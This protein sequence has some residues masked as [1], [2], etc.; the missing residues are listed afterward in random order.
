MIAALA[1]QFDASTVKADLM[2]ASFYDFA[3]EFAEVV[4]MEPMVWNWHIKFM[5]DV[6]Q[7]LVMG[8]VRWQPCE[9]DTII[10]VPPGSTK[11]TILSVML[12]AWAWCVKPSFK[13]LGVSYGLTL[14]H[15]LSMKS[16]DIV[17]SDKYREL[18]PYI[19][20]RKDQDLKSHFA[21]TL[22]GSRFA[23]CIDGP[24]TGMH[25][26]GLVTDDPLD[27]KEGNSEV[28]R[29]RAVTWCRETLPSRKI[30]KSVSFMLTVMQRIH[31]EDP[32]GE[33]LARKKGKIRHICMPAELED[34]PQPPEL[35]AL[36]V[37]G[38]LDPVRMPLHVLRGQES[39]LGAYGYAAQY[40]QRPVP[41]EGGMFKAHRILIDIPG[42]MFR[43]V[44]RYWDKAGTL[45]AGCFTTGVKMAEDVNGR[46]WIL[47]VERFQLDSF[48]R[49]QRIKQVAQMDGR[50]VHVFVEQEPGSGGL[51][52]AEN[53][54]RNLAGFIVKANRPTG[55]KAL[56]AD[57]YSSQVNGGNVSMVS[58][59]WNKAFID[60]HVLFP[61]GKYKD[62][63]DAAAGAFAMLRSPR[64]V[65]KA[66]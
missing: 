9:M 33:A 39:D 10:N 31:E 16:R 15:L 43:R 58:G 50:S 40:R 54:I 61:R 21:N 28:E 45:D 26:H 32:T 62:Q 14:S 29:L 46:F 13:F 12:P 66:H 52:S 55:D 63:V 48:Q 36:Y 18:F 51:E 7:D 47:D 23:T 1:P 49:E 65:I 35:G 42:A 30:D 38:L 24:I 11:S 37:N 53:T 25:G 19:Q 34:G 64:R 44:V 22:G 59:T 4:I 41:R 5:C 2:R 27:P 6:A 20:I 3:R 60:E 56:R 57:P 8:V 17:R